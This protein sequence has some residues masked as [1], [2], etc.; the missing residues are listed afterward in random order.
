MPIAEEFK[1]LAAGNGFGTPLTKLNIDSSLTLNGSLSLE[2]AMNA[3]WNI[4]RMRFGAG[5]TATDINL[6]GGF[7]Y[8]DPSS[9]N[10]SLSYEEITPKSRINGIIS[11][12]EA[13]ENNPDIE[14]LTQSFKSNY[15]NDSSLSLEYFSIDI[16]PWKYAL[17]SEGK[18][19][20]FHGIRFEYSNALYGTHGYGSSNHASVRFD[21]RPMYSSAGLLAVNQN[22]KSAVYGLVSNPEDN[23]QDGF[24]SNFNEVSQSLVNIG[25]LKL[26]K[27]VKFG[28]H[29]TSQGTFPGD[30]FYD[31]NKNPI[32]SAG[33]PLLDFYTYP[34]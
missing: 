30:V 4:S 13:S 27:T 1:A 21:S 14:S 12:I 7:T 29:V 20:Y 34:E 28:N 19:R 11:K 26:V 5:G 25:G 17:D 6:A 9:S 24:S 15:P 2:E 16:Q 33:N 8:R 31:S 18:R 32:T 23:I 22:T 10:G 3:Y